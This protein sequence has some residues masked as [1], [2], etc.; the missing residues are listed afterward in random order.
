MA[1]FTDLKAGDICSESWPLW[2]RA[3]LLWPLGQ[4]YVIFLLLHVQSGMIALPCSVFL[5]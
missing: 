1:E 5:L 3:K 2:A 4:K